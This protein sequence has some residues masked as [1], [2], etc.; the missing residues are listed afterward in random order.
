MVLYWIAGAFGLVAVALCIAA[1]V[2]TRKVL[3]LNRH[4]LRARATVRELRT[5]ELQL[6]SPDE[7]VSDDPVFAPVFEFVGPDGRVHRI[8][9][10]ATSPP[11][12]KV[13]DEISVLF[14][15][16][17][18]SGA[19]IET[20]AGLWLGVLLTGLGAGITL[21]VAGFIL[22]LAVDGR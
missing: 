14:D 11:R 17:D 6:R 10:D 2:G 21:C 5:R 15:P 7:R 19:R 3:Q 16:A 4:G 8:E 22:W 18:P 13:G 1:F 20:F 12:Y 9:G